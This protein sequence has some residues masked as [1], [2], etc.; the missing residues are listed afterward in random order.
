MKIGFVINDLK[1]ELARYTTTHL[2]LA[3]IRRGHEVFVIEVTDFACSTDGRVRARAHRATRDAFAS[4]E[5]Y[6][7]DLRSEEATIADLDVTDLDLLMLRNDPA[8]EIDRSWAK[9]VGIT[10]GRLAASK[11]VIV[12]NDPAG[13]TMARNKK[14][15]QYFPEEVRPRTLITRD[16]ARIKAFAKEQDGPIILKP[17]AGSGGQNVFMAK[18]GDSNI[19]QMI[20]AVRRDGYVIAQEFVPGAEEGDVR[21]FMM[22]GHVLEVDGKH[23]AFRRT[24][25]EGDIRSNMHAGGSASPVV[26]D[27]RIFRLAE[28]VRPRL[29][30][31][32][33]FLVGVDVIGDKIAE[34]NVCSPGGLSTAGQLYGVDFT[35]S[36][37]E[38]LERKT[39]YV[40]FYHRSFDNTDMA[41]L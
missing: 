40:G 20:A 28:M 8:E 31:D 41:T 2:G 18:P 26:L 35:T 10:F 27:E 12:L 9:D 36:V 23:A 29:V 34:I 39:D 16:P 13:L 1:T 37:I 32:G 19:N 14:Y 15:L 30:Q 11:G 6:L 21:V 4:G 17:L 22:N 5:A 7:A 25:A 24:Q 38:A 3:A 33:M